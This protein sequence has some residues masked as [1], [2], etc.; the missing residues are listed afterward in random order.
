MPFWRRFLESDMMIKIS[1]YDPCKKEEWNKFLCTSKNGTFLFDRDYMDYH[2]HRFLDNSLMIYDGEDLVALFPAN[3]ANDCLFSHGGLTYGGLITDKRMN[4]SLMVKIFDNIINYSKNKDLNKI[5]YKAIP[6]IYHSIPSDEDLYALF[7]K[8]AKLFRRDVSSTIYLRKKMAFQKKR[9]HVIKKARFCKAEVKESD[10]FASF[11]NIL[12]SKLFKKYRK[13]PVHT[14]HEIKYLHE[15]FPQNIRLFAS[16]IDDCMLA[17]VVIYES[18]NVAHVQ[19]MAS[20]PDNTAPGSLDIII[21]YLIEDYSSKKIFFDF[22]IS[23]EKEGI[24]LNE[25]LIFF[26]ESFGAR[27]T[28]YDSYR[29]DLHE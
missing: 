7:I 13:E 11:W 17:G 10:D 9:M 16:Y 23:T 19:Y 1:E 21:S 18:T 27:A 24:Y 4:A 14:F 6:Y 20:D 8:G 15:K 5:I 2:K 22:G 3:I 28:A 25:G 12:R 29:I 26:K